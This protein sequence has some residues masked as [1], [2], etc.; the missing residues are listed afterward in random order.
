M[1]Y[2]CDMKFQRPVPEPILKYV[3][4][5]ARLGA[6]D[7]ARACSEEEFHLSRAS[8]ENDATRIRAR[9]DAYLGQ[10]ANMKQQ[11]VDILAVYR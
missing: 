7:Y 2:D 6:Y 1:V 8:S 11:I 4:S 3:A 10:W 5:L 9:R